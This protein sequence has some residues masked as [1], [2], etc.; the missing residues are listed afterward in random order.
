MYN[1]PR[2][3]RLYIPPR[4]S[5]AA[6]GLHAHVQQTLRDSEVAVPMFHGWGASSVGRALRSQRR[7]RG[8]NSPALHQTPSSLTVSLQ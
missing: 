3:T 8:F 5:T 7:G 1:A 6:T 2:E 4:S